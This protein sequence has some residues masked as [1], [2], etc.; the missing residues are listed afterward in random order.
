MQQWFWSLSRAFANTHKPH[1]ENW[2]WKVCYGNSWVKIKRLGG[3]QRAMVAQENRDTG[4]HPTS[5]YT[6]I[7]CHSLLPASPFLPHIVWVSGVRWISARL[8]RQLALLGCACSPGWAGCEQQ[9]CRGSCGSAF[10]LY[11]SLG[12][13]TKLDLPFSSAFPTA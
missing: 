8:E 11:V 9:D 10:L 7:S 6:L 1:F 3:T 2:N 12:F 5:G 13:C 4:T